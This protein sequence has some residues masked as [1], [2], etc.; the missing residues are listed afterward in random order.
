MGKIVRFANRERG[1]EK[2]SFDLI[3]LTSYLF[4]V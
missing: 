4:N 3:W 1:K 2:L